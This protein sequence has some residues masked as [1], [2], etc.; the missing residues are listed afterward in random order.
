MGHYLHTYDRVDFRD[1]DKVEQIQDI[2]RLLASYEIQVIS[3]FE[4]S[5]EIDEYQFRNF[6]A[7]VIWKHVFFNPPD[8][9]FVATI[10][11]YQIRD[12]LV[13]VFNDEEY[14]LIIFAR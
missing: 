8:Q 12:R 11:M 14:E 4:G 2:L 7:D 10:G 9:P 3:K 5:V 13:K 1:A 6:L